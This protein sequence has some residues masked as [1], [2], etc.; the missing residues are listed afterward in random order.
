MEFTAGMQMYYNYIRPHMGI[1]GLTPAQMA[2]I[3]INLMGNRWET[4]IGLA[5]GK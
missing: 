3:P 2:K 5:V 4:M 1:T